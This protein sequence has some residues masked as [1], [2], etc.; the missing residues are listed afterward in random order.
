ML[1]T[2]DFQNNKPM[3]PLSSSATAVIVTILCTYSIARVSR[4]K[5]EARASY[6]KL[7]RWYDALAEQSEKKFRDVGLCKLKAIAGE[8]LLEIG[9]GT[10]HGILALAQEV[11]NSGRV[12][13]LDLS[14]GMLGITR[15]RAE[16]AGLSQ[17]V[18]LIWGDGAKLPFR[19]NC[20]DAIF[21]SF[22]LE[23]FDTPEIPHVLQGCQQVLRPGGRISVVAMSKKKKANWATRLYEWAHRQFP[24]YVDCRPI[25]VQQSLAE[26]GFQITETTEMSMWELPV[27]VVLA[28]KAV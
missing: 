26:S 14:E 17:R 15:A 28:Q 7:S 12:Y 25:F 20:F 10:G 24:K 1:P 5:S 2:E 9:C 18:T 16:K 19:A 23:L 22:T 11:D 21:M 8:H 13:G 6:N 4:S 27:V 3:L